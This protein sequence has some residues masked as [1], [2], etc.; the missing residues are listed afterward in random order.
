MAR[1]GKPRPYRSDEQAQVAALACS[2]PPAG[3]RRWTVALLT[4]A[5]RA[6][7]QMGTI[8]RETIRRLLKKNLKSWRRLMGCIG[9]LTEQYRRR[10]DVLLDLFARPSS[11]R[12]PGRCIDEK[13]KQLAEAHAPCIVPPAGGG[14]QAGS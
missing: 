8:S 3:A 13:G 1:P 2:A 14:G 10:T 5:A 12:E 11:K 9:C 6:H 7:P 4:E